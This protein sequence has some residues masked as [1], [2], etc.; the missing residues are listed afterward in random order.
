MANE[1]FGEK[2][3]PASPKRRA[4]AREQG[5]VAR[6]QEVGTALTVLTAMA[7]LVVFGPAL[8][9]NL[10]DLTRS[11]LA[12]QALPLETTNGAYAAFRQYSVQL[13]GLLAPIVLALLLVGTVSQVV[14]VGFHVSSRPLGPRW[15]VLDPIQGFG[16]RFGRRGWVELLKTLFKVAII[17]LTAFVTV[18]ADLEDLVPLLG[19][20]GGAL[21][22]RIG[23]FTLHLGLRVGLALLVLA[24]LDYGYQKWEFEES[25]R[26]TQKELEDEQK[27]SE[28]DPQVKSRI[29]LLQR[30]MSRNRMIAAVAEADVVITNPIH[31]AVALKYDRGKMDAPIVVAR[32]L[33]KMAERI[34]EEARKHNVPILEDPPLAR[35]LYKETEV[36]QAIPASMYK[37]V[38]QVLAHVWRLRHGTATAGAAR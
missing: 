24:A 7:A 27:Q 9:Q 2:I 26:M 11:L 21:V 13:L 3:H 33:R 10:G 6:S 37:A 20:D 32:G 12:G 35:L 5:Q 8:L 23:L 22:E 34:K 1:S 17:G 38:A 30:Q 15:D 29:R 19:A 4:E 16:R 31:V 14:Q 18:K 36:G 28:G 25:I